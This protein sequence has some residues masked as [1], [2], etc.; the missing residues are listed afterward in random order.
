MVRNWVSY[1]LLINGVYWGYNSL[2]LTID[3]KWPQSGFGN[4]M[5]G[6]LK[7]SI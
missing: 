2:I 7:M 3:P 5:F 6:S 4:G 1:N